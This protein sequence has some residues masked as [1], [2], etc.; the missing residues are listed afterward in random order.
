MNLRALAPWNF[1]PSLADCMSA[2]LLAAAVPCAMASSGLDLRIHEGFV[3][4]AYRWDTAQAG[5]PVLADLLYTLRGPAWPCTQELVQWSAPDALRP[6]GNVVKAEFKGTA[7]RP[8]AV[9]VECGGQLGKRDIA[10]LDWPECPSRQAGLATYWV[11]ASRRT[12]RCL[13]ALPSSPSAGLSATTLAATKEA[14]IVGLSALFQSAPWHNAMK[15]FQVRPCHRY[16]DVVGAL[17]DGSPIVAADDSEVRWAWYYFVA[18]PG[19]RQCREERVRVDLVNSVLAQ[20]ADGTLLLHGQ[21]SVLR[22]SAFDGSAREDARLR[23]VGRREFVDAM[24]KD[25]GTACT[26]DASEKM[27]CRWDVAGPR[28]EAKAPMLGWFRGFEQGVRRV[29][30]SR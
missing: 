9:L 29:F 21:W 7:S 15:D 25:G 8:A 19:P 12:A 2:L 28:G 6:R 30:F 4:A 23:K 13:Q 1:A 20:F 17:A 24:T 22:V 18:L 10:R 11:D 26:A 5:T 14:G 3:G 16:A 27:R